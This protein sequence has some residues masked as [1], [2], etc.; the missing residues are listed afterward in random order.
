MP[1]RVGVPAHEEQVE[2]QHREAEAIVLGSAGHA[3][4]PLALQLGGREQGDA[5]PTGIHSAEVG[6]LERVAVDE[7]DRRLARDHHVALVHVPD[8]VAV[9]VDHVEGGGDVARGPCQEGPGGVRKGRLAVGR[10][11]EG[12]DLAVALDPGHE[13]AD[14]AAGALVREHVLRPGGEGG[15]RFGPELDH[16]P[17]LSARVVVG[18]LG[19]DLGH[20]PRPRRH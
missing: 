16:G 19:V 2:D 4:E 9:A 8:H 10:P 12:V 11:V 7:L 17:E 13:E 15:Q 1:S 18:S 6:D 3:L 5:Y 20:Q 14:H